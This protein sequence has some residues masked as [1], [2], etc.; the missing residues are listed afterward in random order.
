MQDNDF[1][2]KE[3]SPCSTK[4]APLPEFISCVKCGEEVEIW[5]DE[6]ETHCPACMSKVFKK[7]AI[8]H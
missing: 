1:M 5:S 7:E 3:K 6:D 4:K 8:V 2:Q